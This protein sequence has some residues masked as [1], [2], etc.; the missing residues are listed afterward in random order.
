ME[1]EGGVRRSSNLVIKVCFFK[2]S[3]FGGF[4]MDR[5]GRKNNDYWLLLLDHTR[6]HV[7]RRAR[8]DP[9]HLHPLRRPL[10]HLQLFQR[11]VLWPRDSPHHLGS[12]SYASAL[13]LHCD[14]CTS[15]CG[16]ERSCLR[17]A[18]LTWV[19][20]GR[21]CKVFSWWTYYRV[22]GHLGY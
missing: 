7:W 9:E 4:F 3:A 8:M 18:S 21:G 22:G 16:F 19:V 5:T 11:S 1:I 17:L 14:N 20:Y 2:F 15:R 10:L 13:L 12:L 6:L